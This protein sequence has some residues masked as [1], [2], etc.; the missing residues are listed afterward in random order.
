MTVARSRLRIQSGRSRHVN[1]LATGLRHH[2]LQCSPALSKRRVSSRKSSRRT[3]R[4]KRVFES[5][6][7]LTP[8]KSQRY[9]KAFGEVPRISRPTCSANTSRD[10]RSDGELNGSN[11]HLQLQFAAVRETRCLRVGT[12]FPSFRAPMIANDING[13]VGF[14]AFKELR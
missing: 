7:F 6:S 12:R 4:L 14:P 5:G 1:Q 10:F 13:C 8:K 9:V 2:F 3:N 11:R